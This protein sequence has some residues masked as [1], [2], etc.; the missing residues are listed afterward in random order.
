MLQKVIPSY[1][2]KQYSDDDACQAFVDA[3]NGLSQ[4]YV[5][6]YNTVGLP[7]YTELSGLLLDWV[8]G[9]VYDIV[10]P[11]LPFGLKKYLGLLN[12][13]TLNQKIL[14][15]NTREVVNPD[16][17]ATTD[18]V[19][20]RVITW[21]FFKG[22]GFQFSINWLKRRVMR[23]LLGAN[24]KNFNVDQTYRV[25]VTFGVDNAATI[26]LVD[27]VTVLGGNT[28]LIGRAGFN[29]V[30]FNQLDVV[31]MSLDPFPLA[32]VF[33]AAVNAGVLEL[34]FQY[35]WTVNI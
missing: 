29:R 1:L 16:S 25:S 3:Y 6:W 2:Y 12:T 5:D 24:G 31:T 8:G 10:R 27:H 22:D 32:P 11:V 30:Q 26:T 17:F 35:S 19:Y 13:Y 23:F 4:Q 33:Q 28:A 9:G 7:I 15:L 20:Q 14:P 34:P 18:D 21:H